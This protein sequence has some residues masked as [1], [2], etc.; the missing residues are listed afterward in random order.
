MSSS[1]SI[2]NSLS[3]KTE[4][5]KSMSPNYVGMYVCGP[6]GTATGASTGATGAAKPKKGSAGHW[7]WILNSHGGH[8]HHRAEAFKKFGLHH[9]DDEENKKAEK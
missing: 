7:A 3:G 5:F 6:T 2:Y 9:P 1:L 8:T 4:L